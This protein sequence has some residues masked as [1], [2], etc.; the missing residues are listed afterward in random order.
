MLHLRKR[1]PRNSL[2]SVQGSGLML[3]NG[4]LGHWHR[5]F[6]VAMATPLGASTFCLSA[7]MRRQQ[8]TVGFHFYFYVCFFVAN[9]FYQKNKN[10]ASTQ[11]HTQTHA[12]T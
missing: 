6:A 9:N 3:A 10:K 12:E 4:V 8:M 2:G 7:T 1:A 5:S 11:T